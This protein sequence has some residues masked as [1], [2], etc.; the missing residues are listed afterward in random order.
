MT[1]EPLPIKKPLRY[2]IQCAGCKRELEIC[3]SEL[4]DRIAVCPHCNLPNATPVFG[5][6]SGRQKK[7]S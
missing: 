7:G 4:D 3:P 6:L 1:S 5:L 2:V